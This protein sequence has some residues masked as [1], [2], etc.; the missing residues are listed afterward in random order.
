M[1]VMQ[2]TSLKPYNTFGIDVTAE[3]FIAVTSIEDLTQV[4]KNNYSEE[5]FILG[6]G[7]NMLLT[8]D[9]KATVLHINLKGKELIQETDNLYFIP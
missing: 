7:S 5:L 4:L 9:I 6:G 3:R 1:N 8:Q 2:N